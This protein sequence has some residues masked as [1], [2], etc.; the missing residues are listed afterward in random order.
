VTH[1]SL[2]IILAGAIIGGFLGKKGFIKL[3]E[4]Q[5]VD[6]FMMGERKIPLG[7][8]IHLDN[9]H[10]EKYEED[11]KILVIQDRASGL[12]NAV[13]LDVGTVWTDEES[14]LEL[15]VL[16]IVQDFVLDINTGEV[17][18]KSDMPNNPAVYVEIERDGTV[19]REW[20]FALHP[21]FHERKMENIDLFFQYRPGF[22]KD[23]KSQLTVLLDGKK[24]EQK[25]I[26]VNN[27]LKFNGFVFYQ[28]SYDQDEGK[29]SGLQVKKDPGIP[30]VYT[31]FIFMSLGL[32]LQI[33]V[34]PILFV[35][36]KTE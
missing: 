36:R 25:T 15:R 10:I 5:E 33:Y 4:G 24:V 11:E 30:L 28:S 16:Q 35:K 13:L 29:W 1:W 2:L 21:T 18:S 14:N 34:F 6:F 26:E 12:R 9:F 27:P 22:I 7:F 23:Y 17:S 32:I 3:Q 19:H 31:G 20:V 8:S